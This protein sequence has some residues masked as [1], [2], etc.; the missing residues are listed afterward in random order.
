MSI[1]DSIMTQAN[2]KIFRI[3]TKAIEW[4]N[5]NLLYYFD[6]RGKWGTSIIGSHY[7]RTLMTHFYVIFTFV[8]LSC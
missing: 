6:T 1:K 4:K 8:K 3:D 5:I 2:G 7:V